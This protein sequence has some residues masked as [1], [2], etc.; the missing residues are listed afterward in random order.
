MTTVTSQFHLFRLIIVPKAIE[1]GFI[2]NLIRYIG[3]F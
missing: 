2:F 3:Y 1:I